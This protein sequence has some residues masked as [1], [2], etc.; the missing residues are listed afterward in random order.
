MM[1]QWVPHALRNLKGQVE[2]E[3]TR[4]Q[5]ALR[6]TSNLPTD[7]VE[8]LRTALRKNEATLNSA[9]KCALNDTHTQNQTVNPADIMPKSPMGRSTYSPTSQDEKAQPTPV[10]ESVSSQA[11]AS[12]A[13]QNRLGTAGGSGLQTMSGKRGAPGDSKTAGSRLP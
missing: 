3:R 1:P 11:H 12:A 9:D 7:V 10:Q 13:P 5:E 6:D 4:I 2:G 8:A